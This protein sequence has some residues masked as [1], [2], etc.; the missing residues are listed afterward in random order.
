MGA[1]EGSILRYLWSA[2]RAVTP[3]EVLEAID[4]DVAYTTVMTVLA[5]LWQKGTVK[6]ERQGRAYAY[7]PAVSAAEYAADRMQSALGRSVDRTATLAQFVDN[8]SARDALALR[9]ILTE[10]EGNP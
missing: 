7:R 5:R 10:L 1:L 6:R 8:L 4:A 3:G 2:D 9:R